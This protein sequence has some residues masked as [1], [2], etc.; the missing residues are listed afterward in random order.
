MTGQILDQLIADF[1]D[2]E[3]PAL[4][5]RTTE[6]VQIPGKTAV[7]I[8][9]R[10]AGKTWFLFQLMQELLR[11][12]LSK[13]R[14]LYLNFDDDRLEPLD[15]QILSELVDAFY[16]RFPTNR[17]RECWFFLDE[18]HNVPGWEQVVRR[19]LDTERLR[20]V[21]TGSSA[22]L[23]SREIATTLRGRTLTTEVLPFSF[24][25]S[26]RHK[27]VPLPERWP[28]PS[29]V[30]SRLEHEF[31]EYLE[32]G[33]FPEA[34]G[35]PYETRLR[36]FQDYVN[37]VLFR[38]VVERYQVSNTVALRYLVRR[39]VRDPGTSFSI[40]RFH[41]DLRSQGVSVGKDTLYEYLGHLEDAQLI[42]LVGIHSRSER[43]RMRNPRKCYLTDHA[44]S[45]SYSFTATH[46]EGHSLENVVA[47]EL[48]RRSYQVSYLQTKRGFEVDF[49]ARKRGE[50]PEIIQVCADLSDSG[51]RERELRA[52]SEALGEQRLREATIVTL[53]DEET[54]SLG[55]RTVRVVPAWRWILE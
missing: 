38:D 44:L 39:L 25:E 4:T 15:Q 1:Q 35:Q 9:M 50:D 2:R 21:L 40:T 47:I 3:L 19:L 10:R 12:G 26:L 13:D 45:Q 18:I 5:P 34:Q 51:T 24:E 23:M 32:T 29:R 8:G 49:Y 33:G 27:G 28:P 48:G 43:T 37:V 31:A 20:M 36:L 17:E 22:R 7:V 16:R 55:A 41:H 30:R 14:L 53:N 42:H 52:L 54:I 11:S 6:L 46:E